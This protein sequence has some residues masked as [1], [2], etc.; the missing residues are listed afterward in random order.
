MLKT[1]IIKLLTKINL[2]NTIKNIK[3]ILYFTL[4]KIIVIYLLRVFIDFIVRAFHL[5]HFPFM[6]M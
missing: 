3:A 2:V 4:I 5:L 1:L 6:T